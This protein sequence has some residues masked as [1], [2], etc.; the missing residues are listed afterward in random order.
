[1]KAA[2]ALVAL[3][4]AALAAAPA[5][6]GPIRVVTLSTVLTE[7]AGEV[8]GGGV[9]VAGLV[10]PG[11]DP[12]SFNP[13]PSDMR[14]LADADIV[15]ASG[16]NLE[17]HLDRLVAGAG[18]AGRVVA[19]GDA[20]PLVLAA[21]GEGGS[22]EKDPHWWH[23]IDNMLFAVGLVRDEFARARPSSA[24]AFARNAS[25]YRRRLLELKEWVSGEI[26]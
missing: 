25:A 16:L 11:V 14:L 22:G 26:A 6:S 20:L 12:H 9:A 19:V 7:I 24:E 13:S 17:P 15:L 4:L 23:S 5:K 10:Q 21:P 3:G 8:G 18:P 1:M 2:R